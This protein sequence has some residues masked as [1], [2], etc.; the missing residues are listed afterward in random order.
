MRDM[1][2]KMLG[3]VGSQDG[4]HKNEGRVG[5][6]VVTYLRMWVGGRKLGRC[7]VSGRSLVA[8][9]VATTVRSTYR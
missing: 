1:G 7:L 3:V 5:R 6:L 4:A 2:N 9:D 8:G